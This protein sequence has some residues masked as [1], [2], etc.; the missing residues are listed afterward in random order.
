MNRPLPIIFTDIDGTLID[1]DTYSAVETQGVV[2]KLTRKGIPVIL[3]SSKTRQEQEDYRQIFQLNAPFIVENGSAIFI[4]W[5][6]FDFEI[7]FQ[8]RIEPY[9]VLELGI[10]AAVI[11]EA[12]RAIRKQTNLALK[13]YQDLS[14]TEVCSLTGLS[15]AQ[16]EAARQ[17]E[18]SATILTPLPPRDKARLTAALAGVGLQ[19]LAGGRFHTITAAASDK[20][21]AVVQLAACF[22]QKFGNILTVG[23][24]DSANDQSM[25]AS[26]DCP[27]L[28]QNPNVSWEAV[29]NVERVAAIGP[30][31]WRRIGEKILAQS[32]GFQSH[33]V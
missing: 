4:P 21:K 18:Y 19:L 5:G 9:G 8:R 12:L 32:N 11:L 1:F 20:G 16:A 2:H 26:V 33:C 17:R 27:Y 23:L 14:L 7:P 30:K 3:C 13:T 22:R 29:P 31:G 25:L 24:G 10:P 6:T 28:V 15:P